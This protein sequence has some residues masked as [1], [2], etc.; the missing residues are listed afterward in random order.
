MRLGYIVLLGVFAV[1]TKSMNVNAKN[2]YEV[3]LTGKTEIV[4]VENKEP[5]KSQLTSIGKQQCVNRQF[6]VVWFFNNMEQAEVGIERQSA[7]NIF[8]PVPGL[9][10]I[11]SKNKM[12]NELICYDLSG[13][14]C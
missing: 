9:I 13:K 14:D 5:S 6:C 8:D 1:A 11:Y 12:V 2:E 4:L 3:L 10:G 7:G